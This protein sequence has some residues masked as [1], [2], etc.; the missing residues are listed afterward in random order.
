MVF[1]KTD[2]F[3]FDSWLTQY[4]KKLD[5][6]IVRKKERMKKNEIEKLRKKKGESVYRDKNQKE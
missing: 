6:K 5:F 1:F 4:E 3:R 2:G